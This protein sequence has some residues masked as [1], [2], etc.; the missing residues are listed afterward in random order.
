M[1]CRYVM[2]GS[3]VPERHKYLNKDA[4]THFLYI[5]IPAPFIRDNEAEAEKDGKLAYRFAYVDGEVRIVV[6][7]EEKSKVFTDENGQKYLKTWTVGKLIHSYGYETFREIGGMVYEQPSSLTYMLS[8]DMSE[9]EI[10]SGIEEWEKNTE[11]I[12]V[13]WEKYKVKA[14]FNELFPKMT[15]D[16]KP[17]YIDNEM[18]YIVEYRGTENKETN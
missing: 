13:D 16:S 17:V 3:F 2:C 7:P 15:A 14:T 1:K 8:D 5:E 11:K 12:S 9:N 4:D 18:Y 6:F 10:V